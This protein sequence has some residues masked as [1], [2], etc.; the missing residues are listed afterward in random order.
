MNAAVQNVIV[1]KNLSRPERA[2]ACLTCTRR[3]QCPTAGIDSTVQP[4]PR[5]VK[6]GTS[7]Y[8][9][10]DDF[11]GIYIVRSGFLKSYAIDA[12]GGMQVTG[13]HLPGEFVGMDGIESGRYGDHVEALDT[14]SVCKLP[15]ALFN[16]P[17][18]NVSE[19]AGAPNSMM[20]YLVKLMSRAISGDRRMF[21]TLGKMSARRRMGV[22]LTELSE[23]MAK[24]GYSASEFML[25]MS[26]TDIANYLCLAI[27][28]VS[29]L[30]TQLQAEGT[31]AI[32]RRHIR[33]LD[34]NALVRDDFQEKMR[35]AG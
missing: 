34:M 12:D 31:I 19:N 20:S 29:R 27:E 25:C 15:L 18:S 22:F 16:S 11:D 4:T 14:T 1:L 26:R 30:V 7:L 24:S 10:G 2:S 17:A 32:D 28:T 3:G 21:A 33:L 6:A 9:A 23:R 35:R 13:F 5:V 8:E